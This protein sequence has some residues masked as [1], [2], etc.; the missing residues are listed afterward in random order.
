MD[1]Y[2]VEVSTNNVSKTISFKPGQYRTITNTE[3]P[4]YSTTRPGSYQNLTAPSTSTTRYEWT[5]WTWSN[6]GFVKRNSADHLDITLLLKPENESGLRDYTTPAFKYLHD[7]TTRSGYGLSIHTYFCTGCGKALGNATTCGS[8]RT[9]GVTSNVQANTT[10]G[11]LEAVMTFPEFNYSTDNNNCAVLTADKVCNMYTLTLPMY[12][13]YNSSDVNDKF[14]H[15][16]PM[17]LPDGQYTPVTYIS[18]LW[19]PLGEL[20][21]TVQQGQYSNS[22][23]DMN[24][25]HIWSNAI[26]LDG[27]LY[28]DL[29]GN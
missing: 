1:L 7:Y 13:D 15:Y 6:G 26:I 20:T 22:T 16:T 8:C 10:I 3:R 14:A 28:D 4:G 21:A 23:T 9:S 2:T 12:A 17:W 25:L 27:S 18:G 19:T 11:K 5:Y 29:Y 24:R